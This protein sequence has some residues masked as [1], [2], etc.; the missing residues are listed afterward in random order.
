MFPAVVIIVVCCTTVVLFLYKYST[1]TYKYWKTKSVTFAVPVPLFGNIKDHVTL[2]MTQGECLKKIYNDFP[3]EKFVGM[4]QLQTPTLLLRDPETIRLFLV[5]SFA[6]FTD[7]GFLYD[8]HREPL[9][10]HLVNLEGDTWKILRQKLTP[11]FSSGKIKSMLGLL[12]GCGVQLIEYMDATIESGKTE[13]EIRD[14]TAKFTTD[15][16]GT[17]AFGLECN[18]LKDSQSEFRRMGCAVLNSSASLALAKMVRVFFPKLFKALKLRTF[19]AEVQQFFMGI[20]KQTIDF[21]NTNRVRRNDF[22]QLL[23]EIKNQN[24]NQENAINSI[25]LTEEL[26]AAQVFVFFLAGFETSSTTLSFCLHE[27]AVNQDIQ[28]RVYDEIN[29][30]ANV[31]GLPFSYEAISSMNYLEQCLKETMRKY[32]PVQALARVCTKQFRV[33]GTDL[34]LDVGTAVL[35]PVYAIH[36]DPQ[37]YPEPDTFDPDRFAK[38]GD[39]GGG[40]N[41][42]PAGVFLPFGD[43]PRICIGMRFAML[44]MKLALAQFLHSYLVTL[45]EKSCTRIEFEPASFLSCPKGG[46]W[47][48]VNKRKP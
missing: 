43:G 27:M 32:P 36:H 38:D 26:I 9:T 24:H 48:N 31:Y 37:Y 6:H 25:E 33:P 35:I 1:S 2:K 16:I 30:T 45:S 47:L 20:V 12:Q 19:P 13:F 3:R 23:L 8:G 46:I 7:R 34:D 40:D 15:V 44:E 42:R 5:K 21:R 11:T 18:S 17:C 10:K 4:Y 41:G 14:L 28:S 29:E 39:G 22:I